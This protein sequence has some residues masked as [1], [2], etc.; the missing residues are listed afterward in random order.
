MQRILLLEDDIPLGSGIRLA[1][2]S[3][4]VQIIS[5]HAPHGGSDTG[6]SCAIQPR[7]NF[8][9]RSPWGSD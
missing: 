2:Q 5:I 3:P 1:L 9:P 6:G 4:T 8:N 7:S